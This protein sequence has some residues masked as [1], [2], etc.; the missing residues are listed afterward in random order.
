MT[1]LVQVKPIFYMLILVGLMGCQQRKQENLIVNSP[2]SVA[3]STLVDLVAEGDTTTKEEIA[4]AEASLKTFYEEFDS[5]NDNF[6]GFKYEESGEYI[7]ITES[8]SFEEDRL[9]T[10]FKG[11]TEEGGGG[12]QLRVLLSYASGIIE[13]MAHA[14]YLDKGYYKD[15]Y[16]GNFSLS[17]IDE[18]LS[19]LGSTEEISYEYETDLLNHIA[20]MKKHKDQ[21]E[22]E[23]GKFVFYLV[24][25][26]VN[27][28]YGVIDRYQKYCTDSTFYVT[29]IKL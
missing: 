18:G 21:F 5:K 13:H 2:D 6:S 22:L 20:L 7:G 15:P 27:S 28:E 4:Q 25:E 12:Y 11:L 3:V 17:T 8:Y 10:V 14:S 16:L 1:K 29:R 24:H 26:K 23:D 9:R 19:V